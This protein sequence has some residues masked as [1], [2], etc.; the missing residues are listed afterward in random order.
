VT[1][2][3]KEHLT[4]LYSPARA[5]G[6]TKKNILAGWAE[7]GLFLFNPDRVLIEIRK[8]LVLSSDCIA[9]ED[10]E[11]CPEDELV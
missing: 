2:V 1:V 7:S 9:C 8:P 6:L 4:S 3:N 11:Q 5:K 10:V